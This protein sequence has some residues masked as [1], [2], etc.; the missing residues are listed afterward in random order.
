MRLKRKGAVKLGWDTI[1][2]SLREFGLP[3]MVE[4]AARWVEKHPKTVLAGALVL[5][6]AVLLTQSPGETA[7][8]PDAYNGETPLF[9]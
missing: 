1:H 8:D 4:R 9:V 3:P 6:V 5:V 2:T 7:A